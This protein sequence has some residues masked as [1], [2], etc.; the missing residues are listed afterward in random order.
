MAD[1]HRPDG[2]GRDPIGELPVGGARPV[3]IGCRPAY[4]TGLVG[5]EQ[6]AARLS[7]LVLDR[8]ARL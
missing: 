8:G 6:E 7:A 1:A 5:R 2:R 4:L 3:W